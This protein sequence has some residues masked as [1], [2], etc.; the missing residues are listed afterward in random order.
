M[1]TSSDDAQG[2]VNSL[3]HRNPKN[4]SALIGH[5]RLHD[6]RVTL[7]MKKQETK[8]T[9]TVIYRKKQREVVHDNGEQ[10]FHLVKINYLIIFFNDYFKH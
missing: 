9:N 8:S 5:Y 7:V 10:T 3:K 2:S 1:L 6:S 4:L